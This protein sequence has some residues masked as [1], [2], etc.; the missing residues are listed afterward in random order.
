MRRLTWSSLIGTV[1]VL[2][3]CTHYVPMDDQSLKPFARMY[4]VDRDRYGLSPLPKQARVWIDKSGRAG[5]E[6]GYDEMLHIYG[7]AFHHVAFRKEGGGY[8][9]VGEQEQ[10][11]GPTVS[12]R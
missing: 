3:G 6:G 4:A 8:E 7:Q 11:S 9:W 1:M 10:C 12:R 5:P 2:S